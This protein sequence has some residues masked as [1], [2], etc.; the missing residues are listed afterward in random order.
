MDRNLA[1]NRSG[2][3][4]ARSRRVDRTSRPSK[5]GRERERVVRVEREKQKEEKATSDKSACW[6][7]WSFYFLRICFGRLEGDGPG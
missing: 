1:R 3:I 7:R 2:E 4:E 6:L 5:G